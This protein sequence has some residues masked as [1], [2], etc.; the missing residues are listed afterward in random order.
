MKDYIQGILQAE[1]GGIVYCMIWKSWD[2]FK[3]WEKP[4]KVKCNIIAREEM[5]WADVNKWNSCCK[6]RHSLLSNHS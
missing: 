3:T 2:Y 6:E 5:Q 4:K 1:Q